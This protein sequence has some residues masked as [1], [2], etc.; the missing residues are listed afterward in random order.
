MH[1]TSIEPTPSPHTMKLNVNETLP[2]GTTGNYKPENKEDAPAP[3]QQLLEI[4]GIKGVYHVADFMALERHPKADWE[5]LLPQVR[6][7]FGEE[8]EQPAEEPEEPQEAFGEVQAQVQMFKNIPMQIKLLAGEEEKRQGLPERF[9][10]AAFEA[11]LE[12][13]NIVMQ[14]KWEDYGVRYGQDLE[15]IGSDMAEEIAAAYPDERLK[16]LVR[17]ANTPEAE[18]TEPKFKK[19]TME[20]MEEPDWKQRYAAFDQMDPSMEDLPVIQKGLAD[21]KPAIRRLAVVYLG[22]LEDPQVLPDLQ[23]AMQDPSVTVRRTA[24]DTYSDLGDPAGIPDMIEALKDKN[25]LVRW[26]AAMFLYEVGDSSAVEALKEASGDPEFEVDLQIKLALKR[27]E[28]GKEAKGSIWKQMSE[29]ME[30]ERKPRS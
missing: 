18:E 24:A 15:Q 17:I 26:R 5:Q 11:Q 3:I 29:K 12:D 16:R 19:V 27:I 21:E 9:Q 30:Q 22:M 6:Q 25:K 2:A 7:A 8:V 23:K 20:M 13:D 4:E 14:R 1:I 10:T 28:G